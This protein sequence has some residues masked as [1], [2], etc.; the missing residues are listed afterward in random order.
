MHAKVAWN[1]RGDVLFGS[2]NMDNKALK[3][4]FECSLVIQDHRLASQLTQAFEA[5]ATLSIRQT[6]DYF[7][8]LPLSTKLL[9]HV[10]GLTAPLL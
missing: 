5:D 3:G 8:S 7:R 9:S 2:A 10:F 4:N 1:K 6:P